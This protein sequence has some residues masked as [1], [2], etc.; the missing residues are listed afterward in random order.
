[1]FSE[2]NKLFEARNVAGSAKETPKIKE[3][4]FI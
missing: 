4:L 1:M 2:E 3:H